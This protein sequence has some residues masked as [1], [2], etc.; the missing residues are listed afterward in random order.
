[1]HHIGSQ[2]PGR[3]SI[4][5]LLFPQPL[6]GGHRSRLTVREQWDGNAFYSRPISNQRISLFSAF[7]LAISAFHGRTFLSCILP[8][9]AQQLELIQSALLKVNQETSCFPKMFSLNI[10]NLDSF[11]NLWSD[12]VFP[13]IMR[14]RKSRIAQSFLPTSSSN[15]HYFAPSSKTPDLLKKRT[16]LRTT[17][18]KKES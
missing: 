8:R 17:R 6:S 14:S 16:N 5:P 4:L 3:H 10:S 15:P 2:C 1:M 7:R 18:C 11:H 13:R 12:A 9:L